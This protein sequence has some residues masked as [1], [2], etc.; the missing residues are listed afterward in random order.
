MEKYKELSSFIVENVGGKENIENLTHCMTRLRFKLMDDSKVNEAKLKSHSG[1]ITTMK[2]GGLRQIVIGNHVDSVCDTILDQIGNNSC[3]GENNT[4]EKKSVLN[5]L[6]ETITKV[7]VPTL[8]V[9]SASGLIKGLVALLMALSIITEKDGAYI[10][11]NAIG[12]SLFY[13]FPI[14]LGYTSAETFKVNKFVG[15]IVG[16]SLVY[17]NITQ[18][19]TSGNAIYTIFNNTPF[20]TSV[21]STFFGIPIIFPATGYATTVIPIILSIYATSK[22]ERLFKKYIPDIIGFVITPFL[23]LL[24]AVP[25]TIL[26]IGPIANIANLFITYI[27]ETLYAISPL[28][29]SIVIGIVYQPL[30]ILG[31]HWPLITIAI[32]NFATTGSDFILPMIFTASFAQTAAVMAVFL[33]T[34]KKNT[35][36]ICV[37]AIISGLMCIIEPAIYGITLPKKKR[38]VFCCIAGT[39]GGA[40]LTLTSTKMYAVTVGIL[41]FVGFINPNKTMTGVIIAVIATL[42]TMLIAFLLTFITFEEDDEEEHK[43]DNNNTLSIENNDSEFIINNEVIDSPMKGK[44]LPLSDVPDAAFSHN[45]LG[46][47]IAIDP[48]EGKVFAPCDGTLTT[49]FP[50]GHALGITTDSGV[51]IL[52]HIGQ[53]TVQ[54]EGKYFNKIAEQGAKI[55]KGD[56]LL[57]FDIKNIKEQGFS[58]ITPIII[59]NTDSYRDVIDFNKD[60]VSY[61]DKLITVIQ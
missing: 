12:D 8:G 57:E 24:I 31:L 15:M 2:S 56:L 36:V 26:L 13:F 27:T 28:L 29:T 43:E 60:N 59:T 21:Y 48:V 4:T 23:T 55:K 25:L 53:N 38:F 33:R 5:K 6:T 14:V 58:I 35:K 9:L 16:A 44:V 7:I 3:T 30:V 18:S 46:K 19:L 37:P 54:L 22:I 39:I 61:F 45:L 41:G 32:N 10:I 50:T 40:I 20:Q 1:I 11:L 49:F 47:G 51:E 42:V 17:P 34:K 52:I